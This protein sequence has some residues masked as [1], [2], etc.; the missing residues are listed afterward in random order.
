[1][2]AG[3]LAVV[4]VL[5]A[6]Y[7]AVRPDHPL[8][9][10]PVLQATQAAVRNVMLLCPPVQVRGAA[11]RA[12]LT[13]AAAALPKSPATNGP[14]VAR[15]LPL[16]PPL[17][18]PLR[19][20]TRSGVARRVDLGRSDGPTVAV[21]G[22]GALATGLA[23]TQ[24]ATAKVGAARG[25][26][27]GACLPPAVRWHFLGAGSGA[28]HVDRLLL[29]NADPGVAV[30]DLRFFGARGEVR[31]VGAEGLAVAPHSVRVIRVRELVP[32]QPELGI[33]VRARQGRVVAAV[34][35]RWTSGL[36]P[37]GVEWLAPTGAPSRDVVIAG[38][39]AGKGRRTLLVANPSPY[40]ALV[41]VELLGRDGRF[42][43]VGL[44]RLR[45]P[46]GALVRRE[47]A[48]VADGDVASV[49]LH[50]D[51]PV[52]AG[53]RLRGP[54]PG[55]DVAVAAAGAPLT[56]PAV[57]ALPTGSRSLLSLA[58]PTRAGARARVTAYAED[59]SR[60]ADAVLTVA[61][62]T[63]RQWPVPVA[64]KG[65]RSAGYLVV[66]PSSR[67]E[68]VAGA[69]IAGRPEGFLSALP[70]HSMPLSVLRPPVRSSLTG[71]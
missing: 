11:P 31:A 29:A 27:T 46:P 60:L 15:V 45:V 14:G 4:G 68:L 30:V 26:A 19:A 62:G 41:D 33:A 54:E 44:P 8:P 21:L 5:L 25:M 34:R 9:E 16:R 13:V 32:P 3:A 22:R 17:A 66:A 69:V 38:G 43:P 50:S 51:Q 61:G 42:R 40:E 7:A 37:A 10:P 67:G 36:R 1:M 35:D 53:V 52:T 39:L 28:G 65:Q 49:H 23:A 70:L 6:S 56:G 24:H 63:T 58:N 18:T 59:G 55:V 57:L 64:G 47:L 2:G 12:W 48:T 20:L 71:R